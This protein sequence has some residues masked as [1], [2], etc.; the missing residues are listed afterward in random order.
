MYSLIYFLK[1]LIKIQQ[2]F[3]EFTIHC[4]LIKI[5]L[6]FHKPVGDWHSHANMDAKNDMHHSS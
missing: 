5:A 4:D 6:I 2:I 1:G 3:T